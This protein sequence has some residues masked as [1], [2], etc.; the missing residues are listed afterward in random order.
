LLLLFSIY[1]ISSFHAGFFSFSVLFKLME[2]INTRKRVLVSPLSARH[3][4]THRPWLVIQKSRS[5]SSISHLKKMMI[6]DVGWTLWEV[7]WL[8]ALWRPSPFVFARRLLM[9]LFFYLFARPF[10]FLILGCETN[11]IVYSSQPWKAQFFLFG[12]RNFGFMPPVVGWRISSSF[13]C[14]YR[15]QSREQLTFSFF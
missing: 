8:I 7:S 13:F 9:D 12:Q 11:V 6:P 15:L 4:H 1:S 5:S 10:F 14:Y 3:L 2:S